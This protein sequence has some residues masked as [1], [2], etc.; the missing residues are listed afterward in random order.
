MSLLNKAREW[1]TAKVEQA[2]GEPVTYSR[3]GES[4]PVT[5][6][7]GQTLA[8]EIEQGAA[9]IAYSDR[10]YLITVAAL[11]DLGFGRPEIGDTIAHVID[12]EEIVFVIGNLDGAEPAV[13]FIDQS[14][15]VWRIHVKRKET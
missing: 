14:R 4:Y 8:S 1:L 12:G 10:D 7:V 3:S 9:R 6:V 5:A 15:D 2:A 13:R 11:K